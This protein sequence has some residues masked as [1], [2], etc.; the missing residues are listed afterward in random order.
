[1]LAVSRGNANMVELLLDAGCDINAIDDVS[2]TRMRTR[3]SILLNKVVKA[4]MFF[5][6]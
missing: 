6:F 4:V 1:M 3:I 5:I 2:Y